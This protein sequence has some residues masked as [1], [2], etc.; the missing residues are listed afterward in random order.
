MLDQQRQ[1]CKEQGTAEKLVFEEPKSYLLPA[2]IIVRGMKEIILYKDD[3][4]NG[5]L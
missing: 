5:L 3:T 4:G 2:P 1:Y